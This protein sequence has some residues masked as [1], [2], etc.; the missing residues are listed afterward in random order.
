MDDND[1][2]R[3][4]GQTAQEEEA[5]TQLLDSSLATGSGRLFSEPI[6]LRYASGMQSSSDEIPTAPDPE[7]RLSWFRLKFRPH[8]DEWVMHPIDDLISGGHPLIGFL[9]MACAVDYLASFWWGETTKGHVKEAYTGFVREYFVPNLYD[10]DELYESLRVGLVHL[11]SIKDMKYALV[12]DKPDLHLRE[13]DNGQV[14]LNAQN[15]RN[16]LVQAKDGFFDAVESN[17]ALLERVIQR[18]TRDGF[19]RLVDLSFSSTRT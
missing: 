19:L 4:S 8:F 11:F 2:L 14:I 6:G 12:S 16:D 18:H 10:E 13:D 5:M 3:R 17:P 1:I 15:F 7:T 9:V